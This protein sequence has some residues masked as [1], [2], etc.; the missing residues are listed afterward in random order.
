VPHRRHPH[1]HPPVT[2]VGVL[3]SHPLIIGSVV[4][5]TAVLAALAAYDGGSVLL[6][7][8]RPIE[9]WVQ[10]HRTSRLDG[11]FL[12]LSRFGSNVLVFP[13][14]AALV[15]VTYH[16]CRSLA[17]SVALAVL[18]RSPI[19]YVIK[20]LVDRERPDFERLVDGTGPSHPSGHVLAAVA[21]WGLLPPVVGMLTH[22]RLWWW[23]SVAVGAVLIAGSS[24]SRV[25]VGVHWPTDVVQG[26]L[27]GALYLI[28]IEALFDHHHRHRICRVPIAA[29][30]M[31]PR[32]APT[33][34]PTGRPDTRMHGAARGVAHS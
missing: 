13:V 3:V 27:L 2:P 32:R 6:H 10:R 25:Y 31:P 33:A 16:R 1:R 20:M 5:L 26:W 4:V 19:E 21:L 15:I 29:L 18:A 22:R 17:L 7:A 28:G 23:T 11:T 34:A 9:L 14:A 30:A 24:L 8:D 12:T